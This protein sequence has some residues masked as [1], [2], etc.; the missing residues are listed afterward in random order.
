M[1]SLQVLLFST[2]Y[3]SQKLSSDVLE[4]YEV[5]N[6][7]FKNN[8]GI[9]INRQTTDNYVHES[10]L[11]DLDYWN[12]ANKDLGNN[13]CDDLN[14]HEL[15]NQEE[16]ENY[17]DFFLD[18]GQ[19]RLN[20]KLISPNIHLKKECNHAISFPFV[21]TCSK[22]KRYALMYGESIYGPE[23][24]GGEVFLYKKEG[25]KWILIFNFALWIS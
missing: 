17:I 18:M 1:A 10:S 9:D 14:F 23:N 12:E 20:K 3:T 22:N 4:S 7:H 15:F 25:D 11:N 6:N 19:S 24:G 8:K 16:F 21:F 13:D 5:I 2:A